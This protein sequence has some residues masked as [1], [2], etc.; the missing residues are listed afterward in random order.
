MGQFVVSRENPP[1]IWFSATYY[2]HPVEAD[3]PGKSSGVKYRSVV[4][5]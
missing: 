5:V 1:G 3:K 2:P 4:I